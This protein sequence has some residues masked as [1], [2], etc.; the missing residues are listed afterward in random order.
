MTNICALKMARANVNQNLCETPSRVKA[1]NQ[2]PD[3][4]IKLLLGAVNVMSC[5]FV[6]ALTASAFYITEPVND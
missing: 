1:L 3:R 4:G 6:D 2:S 5:L